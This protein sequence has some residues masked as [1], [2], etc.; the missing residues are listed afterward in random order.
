MLFRETQ[1]SGHIF[2]QGDFPATGSPSVSAYYGKAH[3][4]SPLSI[5]VFA[6]QGQLIMIDRTGP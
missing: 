1:P 3:R 4:L 2:D 5:I 6:F